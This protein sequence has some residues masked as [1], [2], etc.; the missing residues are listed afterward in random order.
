MRLFD[1]ILQI[2]HS[3]ASMQLKKLSLL[4]LAVAL[5]L[6]ATAQQSPDTN[7]PSTGQTNSATNAPAAASQP[8]ETNSAN[9]PSAAPTN[10]S[11]MNPPLL[12]TNLLQT[13]PLAPLRGQKERHVTLTECI[14]LALE[15]NL[16]VQI[17]KFNPMVGEYTLKVSYGVYEPSFSLQANKQYQD[18]PGGINPQNGIPFPANL[19]ESDNYTP[20]ISGSLPSGLTYD[21]SGTWSR[22]SVGGTNGLLWL[23]PTWQS[24]PGVTLTQ[25]LLKN[26]WIDRNRLTIQLNKLALKSSEQ[27]FRL[28]METT[29]TSVKTAYYNLI[30]SRENVE[31]NRDAWVLAEQLASEN[32][33]KVEI[34]TLAN[35]DEKQA[36]SQAAASLASLLAAQHTLVTQ[37]NTLKTLL[38]DNY[39]EWADLKPVPAEDLVAVPQMLDRQESWRR[40]LTQR[41]E[42][43]EAQ[44]KVK[45][46]NV[47]L[48]YDFNQRFPQLDLNGSYGHNALDATLSGNFDE[49]AQGNHSFYSYGITASIPL[50]GN[51]AARNTYK[52]D[53]VTL[54]QLLLQLKQQEQTI[55]VDVDNDIGQVQSTLQ[56]VQS[57]HE[58]RIYAEDALKAEQTKLENGKSTSFNVLQLISNLTAAR[59]AEIQALAN[60]NIA[61]AQLDLDEGGTLDSNHIDFTVH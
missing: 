59:V 42:I 8:V 6:A 41:P 38:T 48:K 7:A 22:Q 52:A 17:Q 35:L 27:A 36:E 14:Q 9:A 58:A 29:I 19:T 12:D 34:G 49:L 3:H 30:F 40:A 23:P 15:H 16:D 51:I 13:N 24:D 1:E 53:K 26:M 46:Q 4:T 10:Q 47:T 32:K 60:Y 25:P 37:E 55:M 5:S 21:F 44:L 11:V 33:T 56:Q 31:A 45:Q 54:K 18:R 43:V 2:T 28:Q 39:V 61:Q 57:T 20:G 50:A